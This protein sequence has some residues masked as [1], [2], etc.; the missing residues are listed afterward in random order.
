MFGKIKKVLGVLTDILTFGRS[1]GWWNRGHN[2]E[3]QDPPNYNSPGGF[4]N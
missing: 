4:Y 2:P 1:K 3:F